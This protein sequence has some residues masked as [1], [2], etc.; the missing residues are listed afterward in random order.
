MDQ[1]ILEQLKQI[2]LEEQAILSGN[3]TVDR[4][5][6]ASKQ[7]FVIDSHKLLQKGKLIEIRPHTRFVHFPEHRHNF[8]EMVY[9]Y[10]GTTTHVINGKDKVV[11]QEGD[12]LLLNQH[13]TQEILPASEN[14]IAV[15]F[16][17]LPEFFNQAIHMLENNNFLY[18]FLVSTLSTDSNTPGYLHF[19][20]KDALPV[21]H[22]LENMIWTLLHDQSSKNTMNQITMGLLFMNL[23]NYTDCIRKYDE[24][25]YEQQLVFAALNYIDTHY[26]DGTLEDFA[27]SIH[28]KTYT[29]SRL[30]KKQTERNFKELLIERKLQQAA[31]LLT[32]TTLPTESI[33]HSVGYE[34]SSFFYRQFKKRYGKTPRE[35]R[36]QDSAIRKN[37]I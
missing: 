31:Y 36:R 19:Q 12:I 2:T 35:Y 18:D 17:I 27:D 6:Y 22:L 15:N 8:V 25:Q 33:L 16:I 26:K 4:T 23:L 11:L 24:N 34:N 10:S 14:D 7:Q 13:A 32:N 30:L 1:R 21:H 29:I 9:M 20:T 3:S 37:G 5:L 28:L